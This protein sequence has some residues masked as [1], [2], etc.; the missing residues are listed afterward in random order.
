MAVAQVPMY[1]CAMSGLHT[2]AVAIGLNVAC[3]AWKCQC[4]LSRIRA[5]AAAYQPAPESCLVEDSRDIASMGD[6]RG[7]PPMGDSWDIP[8]RVETQSCAVSHATQVDSENP[9][10][11]RPSDT[12]AIAKNYL[13]GMFWI[14]FIFAFPIDWIALVIVKS[15]GGKCQSPAR[16]KRPL[17]RSNGQQAGMKCLRM[18]CL[19]I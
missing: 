3:R 7:I 13:H 12:K 9:H 11:A 15:T 5:H 10:I 1:V 6:S 17:S 14:D 16:H 19:T 8:V 18:R 2:R 4:A